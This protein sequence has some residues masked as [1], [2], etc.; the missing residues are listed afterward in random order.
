VKRGTLLTNLVF[1]SLS[2]T[3]LAI[4]REKIKEREEGRVKEIRALLLGYP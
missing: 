4:G 2:F 1:H 3:S